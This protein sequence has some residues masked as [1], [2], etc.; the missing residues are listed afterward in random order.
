M[1]CPIC[2]KKLMMKN[3]P[4]F[5]CSI[6]CDNGYDGH[7]FIAENNR[8]KAVLRYIYETL[9]YKFYSIIHDERPRR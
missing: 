8:I 4:L 3:T 7:Y 1:K 9:L 2:G 6:Y 5:I